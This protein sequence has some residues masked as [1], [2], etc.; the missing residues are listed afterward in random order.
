[1]GD[2]II[3]PSSPPAKSTTVDDSSTCH[4]SSMGSSPVALMSTNPR[5]AALHALGGVPSPFMVSSIQMHTEAHLE[6]GGPQ[7]AATEPP[8]PPP[9]DTPTPLVQPSNARV[10]QSIPVSTSTLVSTVLTPRTVDGAPAVP[11]HHSL[12]PQWKG[13]DADAA[14]PRHTPRAPG[15]GQPA[16]HRV[17][18][19]VMDRKRIPEWWE[20]IFCIE[21]L[22]CCESRKP[23]SR[24]GR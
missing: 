13:Q 19:I 7:A 17:E 16:Q 22:G 1:M 6:V 3:H 23:Y 14:S 5:M 20:E 11:S 21:R 9:P 10:G 12:Y 2:A 8:P 24:D 15:A 4:P 18:P